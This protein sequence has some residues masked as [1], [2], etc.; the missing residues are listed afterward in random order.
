MFNATSYW[1]DGVMSSRQMRKQSQ[2][3]PVARQ[4]YARGFTLLELI[5]TIGIFAIIA[6]F[7]I[8]GFQNLI[9]ANRVTT[10]TNNLLSALKTARSEAVR[11]GG[12]VTLAAMDGDFNEGWC[13]YEGGVGTDC[14]SADTLRLFE[15]GGGISIDSDGTNAIEF[16]DQG[17]LASPNNAVDIAV[18]PS[19]CDGD[20]GKRRLINVGLGG[21]ASSTRGDCD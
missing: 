5:I 13:L 2:T 15:V 20:E 4:K 21:R 16:D 12:P 10:Q 19:D 14:D 7:A 1:V 18:D 8:P 11:R 6:G 17:R 9:E 3:S